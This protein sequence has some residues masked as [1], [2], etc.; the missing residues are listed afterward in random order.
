MMTKIEGTQVVLLFHY[1][2]RGAA[3]PIISGTMGRAAVINHAYQGPM[4]QPHT[5]WLCQIDREIHTNKERGCF[6]VTPIQSLPNDKVIRLVPGMFDVEIQD[7]TAIL[8][9][10][11]QGHYW[12]A[13]SAIKKVYL[14]ENRAEILYQSLLVPVLVQQELPQPEGFETEAMNPEPVVTPA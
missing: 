10:R 1:G 12:I 14:K 11:I 2:R 7:H 4:P 9:P 3:N 6:V 13:P 8:K 5:L